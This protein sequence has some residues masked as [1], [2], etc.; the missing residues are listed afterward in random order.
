MSGTVVTT[1]DQLF[2][3]QLQL[4]NDVVLL[5]PISLADIEEYK[6]I[7]FDDAIWKYFVTNVSSDDDVEAFVREAVN[8]RADKSR[9]AFTSIH[10]ATG[11]IAGGTAFLNISFKDSRVE[12]GWSWLAPAFQRSGVNRN[13][14]FLL[15]EYAFETLGF[16]RVEFKTDVLNQQAR[17]GL[18]GI[19]AIEEGVLRSHTLMPFGR[20]R[21]TIYY[22]VLRNEWPEVKNTIF[23]GYG[24]GRGGVV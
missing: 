9:L 22:S 19:G 21:D 10:K 7:A 12:I 15:M 24:S 5:R 11:Q 13:N 8:A 14:K 16:E 1:I 6:K 18:M 17:K 2:A 20:R 23:K 3:Q 4:Q